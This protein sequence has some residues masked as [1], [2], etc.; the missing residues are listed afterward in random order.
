MRALEKSPALRWQ[1]AVD[2]GTGLA[3]MTSKP[4]TR[5]ARLSK[6]RQAVTLLAIGILWTVVV[7]VLV[8]LTLFVIE[9]P[10]RAPTAVPASQFAP[11]K[12]ETTTE[13]AITP[14]DAAN[15]VP[16]LE[17]IPLLGPL[18]R[19]ATEDK[20]S[21]LATGTEIEEVKARLRL[22][23][24]EAALCQAQAQLSENTISQAEY[25]RIEGE[26]QLAQAEVAKDPARAARVRLI[27]AERTFARAAGLREQKLIS[28]AEYQ[29]AEAELR[30]LQAELRAYPNKALSR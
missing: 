23:Q 15:G 13:P 11:A 4:P 26:Q 17:N 5:W 9:P 2:F 8:V 25:D 29:A 7:Y 18:F 3:S 30:I 1:T 27:L 28:E 6:R 24:A 19:K 14:G 20:A 16:V 22:I 12:A 10:Q 21:V